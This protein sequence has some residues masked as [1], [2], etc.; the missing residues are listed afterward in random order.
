M[1]DRLTCWAVDRPR[2][3]CALALLAL[4]GAALMLSRVELVTDP[5]RE[6]GT[7]AA[8]TLRKI[9]TL[10][11]M[12]D[13][14]FVLLEADRAGREADLLKLAG[15]FREGLSRSDGVRSVTYR[16]H[17]DEDQ[18]LVRTT[19]PFWLLYFDSVSLEQ[20]LK[21][22]GL[23][24][25]LALALQRLSLPGLG[26]AERWIERDPLDL[27][28]PLVKRL[29]AFRGNY[30]F[31]PG[32][33]AHLSR[34]GRGLLLTIVGTAPSSDMPTSQRLIAG[35]ERVRRQASTQAWAQGLSVGVTGGYSLAEESERII[36]RD[37]IRSFSISVLLAAMLMAVGLR[38]RLTA[39]PLLCLPTLWGATVG[40]GLFAGLQP[41]LSA[42]S[43]GCSA[44]LIGL[45]VDFTIHLCAAAIVAREA[46]QNARDATLTAIRGTRARLLLA[47]LTSTAAFAAFQLSDQLFLQQMGQLTALGI[48]CCL[49]GAFLVLPS[50]LVRVQAGP[51]RTLG[52]VGVARAAGRHARLGLAGTLALSVLAAISVLRNPEPFETDLRNIHARDSKP[53]ATQRRI[54]QVFGGSREPLLMLI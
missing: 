20:L 38:L 18:Q 36:R 21:P 23:R 13:R 22:T 30:Q 17:F 44:I 43:L 41:R 4:A 40:I 45:G 9:E 2:S 12:E 29:A 16:N 15:A 52:A 50:L 39:V 6:L 53:L 7:P 51:L 3:A 5:T 37:S 32:Q 33:A 25:Q 11:D 48:A 8:L 27:H 35:I 47:A 46:G 1:W 26:P 54:A 42:L 31:K 14:A 28:R 34:D 49:A 19:Q 24:S 10:F